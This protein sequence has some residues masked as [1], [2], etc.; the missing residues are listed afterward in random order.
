M[1]KL[2]SIVILSTTLVG[3][4]QKE[5]VD[6]VNLETGSAYDYMG[7]KIRGTA[8]IPFYLSDKTVENK[9][10]SA[11]SNLSRDFLRDIQRQSSDPLVTGSL[12]VVLFGERLAKEK[13]I[14]DL[15]D[16]FQRDPSI[17]ARLYL[18][19]TEGEAKSVFKGKYGERGNAIYL[20]NLIRHNMKSKDVPRTDLQRFMVDFNQKG[21]SPYLPRIKKLDKENVEIS[22]LSFFRYGHVVDTIPADKMFYF[23]LLVDKYSQ[24]TLKVDIGKE[25]AAIESIKSNYKLRLTSRKP[26]IVQINIQVKAI[27]NEYSGVKITQGKI[28]KI[29][30]K[31]EDDIEVECEK[32]TKRFQSKKTDPVGFGH[33]IKS[34]TRGFNFSKWETDYKDLKV[35]VQADVSIT[36]SGVI[37]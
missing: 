6:D 22:G 2:L 13:G 33:F 32:L 23:K 29:E 10:F 9:T 17:G 19:V 26:L 4:I 34:K 37:D 27:L 15:I 16:S 5:I 24:G 30:K 11:S 14:L 7:G 20:S 18:A 21:K 35:N 36:E 31:L 28:K 3:C 25:A 12:K 8:L 1:K